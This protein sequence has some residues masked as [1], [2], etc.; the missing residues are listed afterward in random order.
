MAAI[1]DVAPS[2][3]ITEVP[4]EYA[5][6]FVLLKPIRIDFDSIHGNIVACFREAQLSFAGVNRHDAQE[7]LLDWILGTYDSLVDKDPL[8]LGP[9]PTRQLDVLKRHVRRA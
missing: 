4:R 7:H 2:N 3:E 9:I 8:T 5:A 6:D 1:R